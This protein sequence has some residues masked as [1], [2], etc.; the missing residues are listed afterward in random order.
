[1]RETLRTG[2]G[3]GTTGW[4]ATTTGSGVRFSQPGL[5]VATTNSRATAM[6]T[7]CEKRSQ[8]LRIVVVKV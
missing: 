7:V 1:M 2:V 4:A 3:R 8:A 5:S 6:V